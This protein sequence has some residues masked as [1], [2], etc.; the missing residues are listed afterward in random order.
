[1]P[2]LVVSAVAEWNGKALQKGSKDVSRF[3][4]TL[5]DLGK[6]IGSVFAVQ[7]VINFGK[8]SVKAFADNQTSAIKLAKAVDNLGLSYS[9][10]DITNFVKTLSEQSGIIETVLRPSL[11]GLLTTTGDVAK[12]QEL[13]TSAIDISRGSSID[14]ATVTTDLSN[15]YVGNYKGLKKY[16]LGITNAQMKTLGF[17]GI[18]KALNT[19]FS[20][21]SQSY[22]KSFAGQMTIFGKAVDDAKIKIGGGL[23]QSFAMLSGGTGGWSSQILKYNRKCNQWN[24]HSDRRL[25]RR[26]SWGLQSIRF[27]WK[28]GRLDS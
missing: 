25:R 15:A 20:G 12:S 4:K 5:I 19:Q 13:L 11:Q 17:T 24:Y 26:S 21:S 6:T 3:Q 22:L 18:M 14:L 2:N 23:V 27:Y 10:P 1:M 7:E 8:E 9:N 28:F 16:E